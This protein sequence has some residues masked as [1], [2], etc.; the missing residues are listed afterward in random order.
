MD[1]IIL[2]LSGTAGVGKDHVGDLIAKKYGFTKIAFSDE[3]KRMCRKIYNF[4]YDQ[5]FG[6]SEERNKQ[7]LRYPIEPEISGNAFCITLNKEVHICSKIISNSSKDTFVIEC[8]GKEYTVT[9][10]DLQYHLTPR[11][12]LQDLGTLINN[13]YDNA[14][15]DIVYKNIQEL[16]ENYDYVGCD[17]FSALGVK[18][19]NYKK[20]PRFLITDHRFLKEIRAT[21]NH[22]GK[23]IRIIRNKKTSLTGLAAQH[24]SEQEQQSIPDSAFDYVL[25]NVNDP[26]ILNNSIDE[27]IIELFPKLNNI[28]K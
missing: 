16:T 13:H 4:S 22:G 3:I 15:V 11:K 24:I 23:V 28:H 6:P 19:V 17:Y 10:E 14:W 25:E 21:Q 12:A 18:E 9:A 26:N 2:G 20:D 27:M 5:C 1:K 7:D 8:E